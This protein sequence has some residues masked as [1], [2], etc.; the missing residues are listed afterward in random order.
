V[1]HRDRA[2]GYTGF[3]RDVVSSS[4]FSW[5]FGGIVVVLIALAVGGAVGFGHPAL[6]IA[7]GGGLLTWGSVVGGWRAVEWFDHPH[8]DGVELW[9]DAL[10]IAIV[11]LAL[12]GMGLVA[13]AIPH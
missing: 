3:M 8:S 2:V 11:L 6:A 7:L 9:W 5:W 12:V 13:L 4:R 10:L 1:P